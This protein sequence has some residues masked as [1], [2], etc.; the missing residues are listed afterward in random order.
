MLG[1]LGLDLAALARSLA[2]SPAWKDMPGATLLVRSAPLPV[3]GVVGHFD[4]AAE[5]RLERLGP[6]LAGA[7]EHLSYVSYSQAEEDCELWRPG[8]SSALAA[9]SCAGSTSPPSPVGG[10]S[11]S[12]CWPT[13]WGW[14][15][16]SWS[17]H[18]CPGLPCC[19]GR[20]RA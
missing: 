6:Q 3:L 2:S 4:A 17:R 19:R 16:L 1:G 5:A 9:R 12:A 14:S 7:I 20:L 8:S 15:T 18:T 13:C 10:I 11:C